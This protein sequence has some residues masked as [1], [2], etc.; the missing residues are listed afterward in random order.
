MD[1]KKLER[2]VKT[3]T[4]VLVIIAIIAAI[5]IYRLRHHMMSMVV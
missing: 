4:K 3:A 2:I 5:Y 1:E